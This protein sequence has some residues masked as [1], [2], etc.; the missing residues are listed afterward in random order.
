MA[1]LLAGIWLVSRH[2][3]FYSL[4]VLL[5]VIQ[6][7]WDQTL[8][9]DRPNAAGDDFVRYGFK[10]DRLRPSRIVDLIRDPVGTLRAEY[11]SPLATDADAAALADKLFPRLQI[12]F[13]QLG[14]VSR[15]G[16]SAADAP[17]LKDW[18]APMSHA[19]VV[20]VQSVAKGD[21]ADAGVVVTISPA[22]QGD[23]GLVFALSLIHISEPTRRS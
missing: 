13:S 17:D 6:A 5:S 22:S 3:R 15:Y 16:I 19:L 7:D 9:A 4:G 1:E 18:A 10:I 8:S 23:L 14:L 12:L 21:S 20:Y 11:A 2:P